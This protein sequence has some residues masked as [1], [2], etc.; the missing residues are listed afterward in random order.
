MEKQSIDRLTPTRDLMD[1]EHQKGAN[2]NFFEYQLS[3]VFDDVIFAQYSDVNKNEEI[4]RDGI[5]LPEQYTTNA[6][7][8]AKVIL[9]GNKVENIKIGDYVMFA[10]NLGVSMRN[11]DVEGI[12]SV[13][14]GLFINEARIFGV[15]KPKDPADITEPVNDPAISGVKL[16]D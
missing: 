8:V 12:G 6:F 9:V 10:N 16:A 15:V 2:M 3:S 5:V 11:V 14:N 13:G 7:R 4:S 1:L